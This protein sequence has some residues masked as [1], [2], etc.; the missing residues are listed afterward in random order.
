[1]AAI[2]K[3]YLKI[4]FQLFCRIIFAGLVS[5]L[6]TEILVGGRGGSCYDCEWLEFF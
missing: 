2:K 1:M 5:T 4:L 6:V 3:V